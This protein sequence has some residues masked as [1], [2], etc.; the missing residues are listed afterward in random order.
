MQPTDSTKITNAQN[1]LDSV[2]R[3]VQERAHDT[4]VIHLADGENISTK[5]TYETLWQRVEGIAKQLA[6][7][8]KPG[9]SAVLCI[10][11]E[12]EFLLALL[13]CFYCQVI[14]I[15][16]L[17]P[18]NDRAIK[19]VE[20]HLLDSG[21][22]I[23]LLDDQ[24][25][26]NLQLKHYQGLL[27]KVLCLNVNNGS[28]QSLNAG[29]PVPKILGDGIA[30]LQY[31]SG[32][33]R[34]PR[35]VMIS[36]GNLLAQEQMLAQKLNIHFANVIVNWMPLHHDFGLVMSLLALFTGGCCVLLPPVRV[37]QQPIRWLR[38]IDRFRATTSAGAVFMFEQCI[39]KIKPEQ[40]QGLDLSHL[41]QV[42]I[43]AEPIH[44]EIVKNFISK[45]TDFGF[46]PQAMWPAFGM[47]E[48]T[49]VVTLK[50]GGQPVLRAFDD[51]AL[52]Q[53]RVVVSENGKLLVSS[54]QP[55]F[56]NS[57]QIVDPETGI[58]C[59]ADVVG[60]LWVKNPCV[61]E[62]Y[63]RQPEITQNTFQARIEGIGEEHYLRTGDLAFIH[64]NEVFIAGRL[65]DTIII[66]GENR[67]PQDIEWVVNQ[68]HPDLEPG[69]VVAIGIDIGGTE[70]LAIV[71]EVKRIARHDLNV[72]AIVN[73]IRAAVTQELGL[74]VHLVAFLQP[75]SLPK[76][77]SGKVQRQGCK[78]SLLNKELPTIAVWGLTDPDTYKDTSSDNDEL[79]A[80]CQTILNDANLGS[81]DNLFAHGADSIK[82]VELITEIESR[83]QCQID[84]VQF[85]QWPTVNRLLDLI[86]SKPG[87]KD[88]IA[89]S[90][91]SSD[92]HGLPKGLFKPFA[93]EALHELLAF[94]SAWQAEWVSPS[95]LIFGMNTQGTKPPLFW[96][97]QGHQEF[98]QLARYLGEDQ[99]LY[100]FRSGHLVIEYTDKAVITGLAAHYLEELLNCLPQPYYLLGGNCQAGVL[101]TRMAQLLVG[102]GGKVRQLFILEN[103]VPRIDASMVPFKAALFFGRYSPEINPYLQFPSPDSVWQR[104]YPAGYSIDII[105][106][107]HGKFFDEPGIDDFANKLRQRLD[108]TG[109]ILDTGFLP[110]SAFSAL[111]KADPISEW[112]VGASVL[113]SIQ[114][115]NTSRE[116]WVA[117][118]QSML[119]VANHW[120]DHEGKT[121]QWLDGYVPIVGTVLPGGRLTVTLPVT[122]PKNP[123]SYI[124]EIDLAE[125]G[126]AWFKEKGNQTCRILVDVKKEAE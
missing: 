74:D 45:F 38:A 92:F 16:S 42:I 24:T 111:I 37:V 2:F 27:T 33:T 29:L 48:A 82:S 112:R 114:I 70:C 23:V 49:L 32:S 116:S 34:E 94:T 102:L 53:K 21:A 61:G 66:N 72:G 39:R 122:V 15:P 126:I 13:S 11:N 103:I 98:S 125:Q 96:C 31:T 54:G 60:E 107:E 67:Y 69:A 22:A 7:H 117:E 80:L 12:A 93:E 118:G 63:W 19:R 17:T 79:L 28:N 88:S 1:F 26:K 75:A 25:E 8:A 99:P 90:A 62:G 110:D 109:K 121:L 51:V 84:L 120:L 59:P 50:R 77:S 57:V 124:L 95:R 55:A 87:E 106:S 52:Q 64:Q 101:A 81:N 100:G 97:F 5:Y 85:N 115:N 44:A 43:G 18:T 47:A 105:N 4:A 68:C 9:D 86:T 40:C 20:S 41:Q 58:D 104:L 56:E 119:I 91:K 36:H 123:G 14:A 71:C 83:W 46:K 3:N 113:M 65:K 10:D 76:T 89:Q 35:G 6:Q 108:A 73:A 78:R 30:Y